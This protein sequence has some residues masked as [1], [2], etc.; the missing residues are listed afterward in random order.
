[1]MAEK[2]ARGCEYRYKN[3][4]R[5]AQAPYGVLALIP[6]LDDLS[7]NP[8]LKFTELINFG[9][10]CQVRRGQRQKTQTSSDT[11]LRSGVLH[12]KV[13][14]DFQDYLNEFGKTLPK[15]GGVLALTHP[16]IQVPEYLRSFTK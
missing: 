4:K 16:A 2:I 10:G 9:P 15:P 3:Q 13:L 5:Y 8:L 6:N 11:L 7:D 1:M 12:F 14:I